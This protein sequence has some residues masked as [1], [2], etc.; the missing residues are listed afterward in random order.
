MPRFHV[1]GIS[2]ELT[3]ALVF[4]TSTGTFLPCLTTSRVGLPSVVEAMFA[5]LVATTDI[6]HWAPLP[7]NHDLPGSDWYCVALIAKPVPSRGVELVPTERLL[8]DGALPRSQRQALSIALSRLKSPV[9]PFDSATQVAQAL[10]WAERLITGQCGNHVLGRSR[11]RCERYNYVVEY[12]TTEGLMYLKGG[13]DRIAD[14]AVLADRLWS[15]RPRQ[16]PETVAIDRTRH[17]WLYRAVPGQP[18][19]RELNAASAAAA[20]RALASLQKE[21]LDAPSVES[22]LFDRHLN[23]VDLLQRVDEIVEDACAS[24]PSIPEDAYPIT[25]WR[26]SIQTIRKRCDA[27]DALALPKALVI[28]DFWTGNILVTPDGFG[29]I[30]VGYSYW[31]YPFIPLWRLTRDVERRL[32]T[33]DAYTVITRAFVDEWASAVP[34]ERMLHALESFEL[35]GRLFAVLMASLTSDLHQRG[36]GIELPAGYRAGYLASRVRRV[37]ATIH[38]H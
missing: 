25:A 4:R 32:R 38:V 16:L 1:V 19:T 18:L 6:V 30:D 2:T 37:L 28:S 29:F 9:H 35:L 22:H 7:S 21:T 31:S 23:A 26:R 10:A 27:V 13:S 34:P 17:C 14:E 12:S 15:L 3:H 20:A 24:I 33:G 8:T 36:L 5:Q 11:L